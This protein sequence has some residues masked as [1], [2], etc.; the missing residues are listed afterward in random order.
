MPYSV[1]DYRPAHRVSSSALAAHQNCYTQ[2]Q[3][4]SLKFSLKPCHWWDRDAKCP[5]ISLAY[6]TSTLLVTAVS[7]MW[8]TTQLNTFCQN[9]SK[10]Y[11]ADLYIFGET[12][13]SVLVSDHDKRSLQYEHPAIGALNN[14]LLSLYTTA[15]TACTTCSNSIILNTCGTNTWYLLLHHDCLA[16]T[17][18]QPSFGVANQQNYFSSL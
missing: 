18:C 14:I 2:L 7:Q 11:I 12:D 9:H 10:L 3:I 6:N 4:W 16:C 17:S 15:C 13:A 8:T 1:L 5:C